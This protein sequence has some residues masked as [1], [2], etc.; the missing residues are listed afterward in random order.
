MDN[1]KPTKTTDMVIAAMRSRKYNAF[2]D[3]ELLDAMLDEYLLH[4]TEEDTYY[5]NYYEMR[6]LSLRNEV[7]ERMF[8]TEE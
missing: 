4:K 8:A 5:Q 1:G 7:I 3:D 6:Y 2:Q